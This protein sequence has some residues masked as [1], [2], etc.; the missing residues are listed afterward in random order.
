VRTKSRLERFCLAAATIGALAALGATSLPRAWTHW[1]YSRAIELPAA[2]A[3][4]LA[5]VVVPQDAYAHLQRGLGDVRVIDDAGT[6]V[7]YARFVRLGSASS[8]S[9]STTLLEN[10][11]SPGRYTQLVL[12][13]GRQAPFHNAVR[14]QTSQADYIEWVQVEASDD[15]RV[16][17]IVQERAPIFRFQKQGHEGTQIVSYSEN[18][19]LYLRVRILDGEKQF[20]V[21]GATILYQT[22]EPPERI[23]V[24]I[25][26]VPDANPPAGRS[27]W[28]ADFGAGAVPVAEVRFEVPGRGEFIRAVE[29][30]TSDDRKEWS[31]FVRGEIY[32]YHQAEKMQ[33]HLTV[34]VSYE[35]PSGRYWRVEIVNGNDA[36]LEGATPHFYATPRHIIFEQQPGRSYRLIYSQYRAEAPQYDLERRLSTK[37][38]EAAITGQTGPEEE[39]ADYSDPRPW[40]EQHAIFLWIVLG[41]VVVLLGY[42]AIRSLRRSAPPPNPKE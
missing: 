37:Q 20:P 29:L 8:V 38:E 25:G 14:I 7:P 18:N 32:R 30:S 31:T 6:E 22:S 5:S 15:A 23:P 35:E 42:S 1:R 16:W 21:T 12:N 24:E 10:S 36:P 26:V 39:N 2:D 19:A 41:I 13:I 4:R 28:I 34:S 11:F 33:E 9:L 40:T 17:R 27:G 3:T